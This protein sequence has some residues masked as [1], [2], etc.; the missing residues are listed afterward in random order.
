MTR[1]PSATSD[2]PFGAAL[3]S[4]VRNRG[5]TLERIRWHLANR[6]VQI[7]L[8]S[9]SDWQHGRS[10]PASAKS[11]RAVRALEEVLDLRPDSLSP[12]I[13]VSR[14]ALTTAERL[15]ESDSPVA[16]LLT[17]V[18]DTSGQF[19]VLTRHC[20]ITV[21]RHGRASVVRDHTVI[22]AHH[23]GLDRYTMRYF[24]E[25]GCR[26]DE[27]R[28]GVLENCRLGRV[29]RRPDP[30]EPAMVAELLFDQPLRSGE[31]WVFA[32]ELID[33][34][35]EPCTTYGHGFRQP[36]SQFTLAVRFDPAVDPV[37]PHS[38]AEDGLRTGRHRLHDLRLSADRT[39][40]LVASD[41]RSGVLGIAWS[42]ATPPENRASD[43]S[44]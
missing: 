44:T 18:A 1:S 16:P 38:F 2:A 42:W 26:I 30:R 20:R 39:A 11:L 17:S 13:S 43:C 34:T 9:L 32:T 5:L 33:E 23:D 15:D 31:S 37:R 21:D 10:V 19:D 28:F 6:G 22:R 3:R 36:V 8:S 4:A 7:G 40:H 29:V 24:G 27:V 25:P 14:R 35:G 41:V 12:L